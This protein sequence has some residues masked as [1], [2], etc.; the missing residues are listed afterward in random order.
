[1]NQLINGFGTIQEFL[2]DAAHDMIPEVVHAAFSAGLQD[3]RIQTVAGGAGLIAAGI[4]AIHASGIPKTLCSWFSQSPSAVQEEKNLSKR[5]CRWGG[6]LIG[7]AGICVGVSAIA[8]GVQEFTECLYPYE[9]QGPNERPRS[10]CIS[11]NPHAMTKEN[12]YWEWRQKC[13]DPYPGPG[14]GPDPDCVCTN[15]D[16]NRDVDPD[17][18]FGA[19]EMRWNYH[20]FPGAHS[21][22]S[23]I[24]GSRAFEI[25][26]L[27]QDPETYRVLNDLEYEL[28]NDNDTG[29]QYRKI[30]DIKDRKEADELA[31]EMYSRFLDRYRPYG[32]DEE[33]AV[34]RVTEEV[35]FLN[36]MP[37]GG[38][39]LGVRR[40]HD[41]EESFQR[42][43]L[44]CEGGFYNTWNGY[45]I[46][47]GLTKRH[48]LMH[49]EERSYFREHKTELFTVTRDLMELD[50]IH[51]QINHIDLAAEVDYEKEIPIP[52]RISKGCDDFQIPLGKFI[53][54]YR[55][56]EKTK[57]NLAE[58]LSSKES[59]EFLTS[60]ESNPL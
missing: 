50:Q 56:L 59:I 1:M 60:C 51:K 22:F 15:P 48:E 49:L 57:P 6:A 53:N 47:E 24:T 16:Q 21:D 44:S 17:C 2:A 42:I 18:I 3:E 5:V 36:E 43:V 8:I 34:Y 29:G 46:P 19:N 27:H 14:A 41:D 9:N 38:G 25:E 35:C 45:F 55:E 39:F 58:T 31:N 23:P 37:F 52:S 13:S 54:F 40:H 30:L 10:D 28:Y 26:K 33:N 11:R 7:L 4:G 20:C 32:I 12:G